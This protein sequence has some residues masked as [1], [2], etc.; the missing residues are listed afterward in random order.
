DATE[1]HQTFV[2]PGGIPVE[3]V[4]GRVKFSG[5][6]MAQG[7]VGFSACP[8]GRRL[9]RLMAEQMDPERDTR[10]FQGG[11]IAS[12]AQHLIEGEESPIN[13]DRETFQETYQDWAVVSRN[14]SW[15]ACLSAYVCPPVQSRWGQDR[16]SYLSLWHDDLGLLLGGGNS[17]DQADWSSFVANGKLMPD[18]GEILPNINGIALTYGNIRCLMQL[19]FEEQNVLIE[20]TAEGGPALQQF[21][22]QAKIGTTIRSAAGNE[23]TLGEDPVIWGH[24]K[25]GDWIEIKGVRIHVPQGAEFRWP[26][27]AF[28]PYA[29][30]GAAT[31]GS[32]AG[33]L[34]ARLDNSS[35]QW[36]ISK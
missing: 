17:K 5:R 35:I 16:Q 26:T 31:F 24:G 11:A 2:Y 20:A 33:I 30:D 6:T 13:L 23:V 8:K 1:F 12:A 34:A 14:K 15:F 27:N 4:D 29:A 22:V 21:I 9:V 32:E 25:I 28:N 10:N 3:T 7:W 36:K 19:R 18:Q